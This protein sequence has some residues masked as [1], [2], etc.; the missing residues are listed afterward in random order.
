MPEVV[1]ISTAV[2][3]SL[4]PST[5]ALDCLS[6]SGVETTQHEAASKTTS[7]QSDLGEFTQ[8]IATARG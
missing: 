4:R 7:D 1:T 3:S 6:G 8:A 2:L 5:Q